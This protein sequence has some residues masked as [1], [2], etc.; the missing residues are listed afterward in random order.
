MRKIYCLGLHKTGSTSLQRFLLA[1]QVVLAQRGLLFPPVTPQAISRF[2]AELL[3]A[4][5]KRAMRLN[6][7]MGHNALAYRMI[8]ERL[9]SFDFPTGHL[10]AFSSAHALFLARDMA[11]Q[12]AAE[13]VVF[14]SEDLARASLMVPEVP[15]IFAETFGTEAVTILA[16]VRRP[17]EALAAWQTQK[18]RFGAPFEPLW[19]T[20]IAP[21]LGTVHLEYRPALEPWRKAFPEADFVM[22][23]YDEVKA[24]GGTVARFCALA[25]LEQD[26]LAGLS[27]RSNPSLPNAVFEIARLALAQLP[28][29]SATALRGFLGRWAQTQEL[30]AN[31][32]VDM[33]GAQARSALLRSFEDT[34]HWLSQTSG[35]LPFFPSLAQMGAAADLSAQEA[36]VR[37]LPGL[38]ASADAGLN[39]P[40]ARRFLQKLSEADLRMG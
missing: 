23:P 20:G 21:Y 4:G 38:R 24:T 22:V 33:L 7:Y 3:P 40:R 1:N 30:P 18:L 11:E 15:S 13:T 12:M 19:K 17:D 36:A 37:A 9:K 35:R 2:V 39:D 6:E 32:D 8:S 14:C 5:Q 10:P 28:L 27:E 34:H 25:G 26:G 16:I 29:P 31:Q